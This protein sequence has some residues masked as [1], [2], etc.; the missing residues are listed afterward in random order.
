[1]LVTVIDS[2][3]V[4]AV[5]IVRVK[6]TTDPIG[7]ALPLKRVMGAT[8]TYSDSVFFSIINSDSSARRIKVL[9]KD[10]VIA[11]YAEA[12]PARQDSSTT[13]W[14]GTTGQIGP[15]ASI[16]RG[17]TDKMVINLYDPDLTAPGQTIHVTSTKDP[18][19]IDLVL[20]AVNGS[21]GFF[22]SELGFSFAASVAG[23]VL[24]V[25]GSSPDGDPLTM[26][27]NDVS[28]VAT[29]HGS[30]CTWWPVTGS[31]TLD[32]TDYHG[33]T[34]RMTI[35]LVDGDII[36]SSAVV[37]I[38]SEKDVVGIRDTLK[39]DAG[40]PG[41]FRG[42]VSFSTVASAPRVIAVQANDTVSVTYQDDTPVQTITQEA[43]WNSH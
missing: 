42:Q 15:G 38:K 24:A 29:L 11:S 14:S 5:V 7:I 34:S 17:L 1:M 10:M 12:S 20:N 3:L 41:Q 36:D 30:I 40:T 32:S 35:V 8:G 28:P 18:V 27:Y 43:L 23:S 6:S 26:T 9:D 31:I 37:S 16:Y 39:M 13:A 2:D 19:G 25:D 22:S 21:P 33:T 4:G